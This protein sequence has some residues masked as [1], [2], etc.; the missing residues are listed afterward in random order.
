MD[1]VTR[2]NF[3]RGMSAGTVAGYFAT[4]GVASTVFKKALTP[5]KTFAKTDIG[6][7]KSVTVKC[8]SE[9]SWFNNKVQMGDFKRCGGGLVR[10]HE[11]KFT[12]EGVAD[13]Y[14]GRNAGGYSTLV[15]I[16]FLDGSHKKVL[17]DTGWNVDWMN[18]RFEEEGID[19]M[20]RNKEIEFL[21]VS[22]DHYDH[23]W[24]VEATLKHWPDIAMMIPNTFMKESYELLAGGS[25]PNPP[26]S[27][28]VPHK[29]EL[30]KHD[31]GKIYQLFPGVVSVTFGVPCGRGVYGEQVLI[32]NLQDKGIATVSGC[33]HMGLITLMEYMKHHIKGGEEVYGVYGGLHVSPYDDWDP[34]NDDLVLNIPKYK[35]KRL[36]CNHCTGYITA[37]KMIKAGIPVVKGT[38]RN[39]TRR[40]IYL[41]NGD[42]FVL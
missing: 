30:I 27:N 3:I 24:G 15:D 8:I 6:E 10:Q 21:F 14:K 17:L 19:R 2:R 40:D 26:I 42:T 38:G 33:C 9:T 23:F 12:N 22:H 32:F 28:A 7:C 18:H 5:E 11:V 20:L 16:E 39:K 34:M 36:G 31:I 35:V 13:G 4:T 1:K 41:G 29:G 37:E 25:F